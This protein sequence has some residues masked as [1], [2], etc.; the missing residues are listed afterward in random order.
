MGA[1]SRT[2]AYFSEIILGMWTYIRGAYSK[3]G[4]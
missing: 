4:V 2:E 1:H 3:E